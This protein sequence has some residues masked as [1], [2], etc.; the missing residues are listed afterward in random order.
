MRPII[1]I[2]FFY[3]QYF[4]FE[5]L[6][7]VFFKMFPTV[8]SSFSNR[9]LWYGKIPISKLIVYVMTLFDNTP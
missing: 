2:S 9:V 7:D 8:H 4:I 3:Y 5:T 6:A 1:M